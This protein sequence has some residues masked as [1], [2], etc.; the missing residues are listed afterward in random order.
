MSPGRLLDG[1]ET[2]PRALHVGRDGGVIM[3]IHRI[4]RYIILIAVERAANFHLF[5]IIGELFGNWRS[6]RKHLVEI[7]LNTRTRD[8]RHG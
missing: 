1:H 7:H 8:T 6:T 2:S 3:R 5:T 4:G